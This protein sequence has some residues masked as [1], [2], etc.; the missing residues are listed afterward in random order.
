M[1]TPKHFREHTQDVAIF[2]NV[3]RGEYGPLAFAGRRVLDVGAHIGGFSVLAAS[4]GAQQV[5]A[6]EANEANHELLSKNC[7]GLPVVCHL[8]AVWRSDIQERLVWQPSLDLPNTGGGGMAYGESNLEVLGLD[9]I[10]KTYGPFDI[11]KL[12]CEGAEIPI[13]LTSNNFQQIPLL[14]GEYHLARHMNKGT[15]DVFHRLRNSGYSVELK[16]TAES[17]G[18]F[19]ATRSVR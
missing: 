2:Q 9:D 7:D 16:P 12:D 14:V 18:L 13:L 6:F 10:L 1:I 4:S 3:T 11:L 19:T 5:H 17:F 8:A 15:E